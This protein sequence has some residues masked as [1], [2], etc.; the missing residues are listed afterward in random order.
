[1]HPTL[2][3]IA[4]GN[5]RTRFGSFD[6]SGDLSGAQSLPN[7][8]LSA[9]HLALRELLTTAPDVP[10]IMSSV[11]ETVTRA[12]STAIDADS[13][14]TV[15][16]INRDIRIPMMHSLDDATT[17]GDDRML[18]AFAAYRKAQQACVVIDAGTAITVD[19]VDGVGTFHGGA[20]APGLQMMVRAL[21]EHTSSLPKIE[22]AAPDSARGPFGKDTR[23]AM[24]L[25]A[26][27]AAIGLVRYLVDQYAAHYEAYPQVVAT[28]G[29]SPTLFENDPLVEHIVP[30]L[31]LIGIHE[32]FK[33]AQQDTPADE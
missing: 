14:Q 18:C 6:A 19:F 27:A 7:S 12:L 26:H 21:H 16:R 1:M 31:Q 5:T 17:L 30:D 13:S 32:A 10:V 29:D 23:H 8:D 28:G 33:S 24:I 20:I 11:N 3:A 25:G 2:F 15:L 4:V 9:L 22:Y